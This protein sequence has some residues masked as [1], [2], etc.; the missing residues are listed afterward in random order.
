MDAS[1]LNHIHPR[2]GDNP[3][4]AIFTGHPAANHQATA[5]TLL[6]VFLSGAVINRHNCQEYDVGAWNSSVH[7]LVS[8][9]QNKRFIPI[10]RRQESVGCIAD[11]WMERHE[12]EAFNDPE[13]RKAQ[14]ERVRRDVLARRFDRD[15]QRALKLV[16]GAKDFDI[17][18][19]YPFVVQGLET[20]RR[21]CGAA[22]QKEMRRA[23][24]APA[25]KGFVQT[26]DHRDGRP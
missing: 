14:A 12:I 5:D 25:Q 15:I 11:Y 20:I 2:T 4:G 13:Q 17:I 23:M 7:S 19:R 9:L 26:H 6:R 21:E 18:Q 10:E 3:D 1:N 16:R 22:L 24:T 8:T